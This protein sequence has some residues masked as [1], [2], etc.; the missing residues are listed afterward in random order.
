MMRRF[1]FFFWSEKTKLCRFHCVA[2]DETLPN[3]TKNYLA[4]L[5][6]HI[7]SPNSPANSDI[8]RKYDIFTPEKMR[9]T[10]SEKYL[11]NET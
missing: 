6:T 1:F 11:N 9:T 2:K 4:A 10:Q 7:G 3:A 5:I 8:R